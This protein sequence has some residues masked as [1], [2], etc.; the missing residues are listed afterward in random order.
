M[1]KGWNIISSR[2]EW[3]AAPA[4]KEYFIVAISERDAAVA[5]LRQS[6]EDLGDAD[7]MVVAA[8]RP[9]EIDWLKAKAGDIFAVVIVA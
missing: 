5:A 9:S 1:A 6:R 8:A 4:L 7:M 3:G 2:K